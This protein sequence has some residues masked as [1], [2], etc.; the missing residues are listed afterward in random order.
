MNFTYYLLKSASSGQNL[1]QKITEGVLS[2]PGKILPL[3]D[4]TSN[5][6]AEWDS[7]DN[8]GLTVESEHNAWI[9]H[10][11]KELAT[12]GIYALDSSKAR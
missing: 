3:R 4:F 6:C 8:Q 11:C 9:S 5:K 2:L 12:S 10:D 1:S 7:F